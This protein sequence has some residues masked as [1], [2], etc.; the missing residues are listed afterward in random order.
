MRRSRRRRT[1][2]AARG[3]ERRASAESRKKQRIIGHLVSLSGMHGLIACEMAP[4]ET[5]RSLVGRQ[6]I[7]VVHADVAP[8]R[9]RLRA[10]RPPNSRWQRGREPTLRWSRSNSAAKS[11][12]N[13]GQA[14]ILSRH[15]FLSDARLGRAS[16]PRRRSAGDLLASAAS[17]RRDRPPDAEPDG[18]RHRQHQGI[19][20]A[21]FRGRRLDRR[22]QDDGGFDAAEDSACANVP[23]C[24]CIIIDPHNEY[25]AHFPED[26]IVLDSDNLELPYWM[27][28]FEEIVDI[29]Y[30]GRKP[31]PDE[32]RR[33]IRG[34]QVRQDAIRATPPP[35][36][37]SPLRRQSGSEGG[38][39]SADTPVPYRVSDAVQIIDEWMG[40]LDQRYPRRHA[41]AQASL[42][43]AEPRSALSASCSARS[44]SKTTWRRS[45]RRY[46]ACPRPARR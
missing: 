37:L 43:G 7:S 45:S 16:H 8:G 36:R 18:P 25:A 30:A 33:A 17:G 27:F 31:N 15:S 29:I 20:H 10:R 23:S 6:L 44:S 26:S 32:M 11:S 14:G 1:R 35:R 28:K 41:R 22:R 46:S 13:S 24:A 34:H 4:E 12:T 42:G 19:G 5:G 21:P 9:R 3:S 40:K 2:A 39:V 38:W